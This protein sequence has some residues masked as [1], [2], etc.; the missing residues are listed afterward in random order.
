MPDSEVVV[1]VKNVSKSFD[2]GSY[3]VHALKDVSLKAY[4]NELLMIIGPSGCGKTT[5]L[6]VIAGTLSF[7]S[8]AVDVF[9]TCLNDL[10]EEQITKFRCEHVGFIFQQFHL[11]PTLNCLENVAIPLLLQ[12]EKM[13]VALEKASVMMDM[14]GLKGKE[15]AKPKHL[16][17]GQQQRVAIAR[18]LVHNPGL[19]ICDEPTSSLDAST[20]ELVMSILSEIA[21]KHE[22]CVMIVTHDNRV[23]HY[24]D[25]MIEMN[26]GRIIE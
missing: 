11:I 7:D 9:N 24:A 2:Q 26:D 25:R 15:L 14:I 18:A 8:G 12:N 1:C 20:G 5:L 16:S 13:S 19:I 17:G 21:K 4:K 6:S 10:K 22:R 23:F 3:I